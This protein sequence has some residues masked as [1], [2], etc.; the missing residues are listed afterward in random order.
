MFEPG[1]RQ[2]IISLDISPRHLRRIT[3]RAFASQ[4]AAGA[5]A[6][7]LGL[8]RAVR[9]QP[10]DRKLG[11]ALVGLGRYSTGELGPALRETQY[12]RLAGVVTG[13]REKGQKWARDFGF[14]DQNVFAY[15]DMERLADA[16]DIDSVYVV[17]P[18]S[19][20]A[21]HAIA[22]AK[23]GKHVI[24]EKPFTTSVAD[25]ETVI[26]AC[27]TAKVKL[28]VGYRLHFDPYHREL[29][30]LAREQDFGKFTRARGNLS[31]KVSE[32]DWRTDSALAGGGP[33]MDIGIYVIQAACMTA[34]EATPIAVTAKEF[35]DDVADARIVVDHQYADRGT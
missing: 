5:T 19:L 29:M 16:T 1:F 13:S 15:H 27:Q 11:V 28:S 10:Q 14:P 4:V 17:T 7:T 32:K 6:I 2:V 20:H 25:A 23:A 34:G 9:S 8:S 3:R 24:S 31:F 35:G 12:C 21:V 33:L 22:A 26:A 30:R 18:N